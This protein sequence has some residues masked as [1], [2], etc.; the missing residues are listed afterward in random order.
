LHNAR[1]LYRLRFADACP[2]PRIALS[3]SSDMGSE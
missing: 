2:H 3:A 1:Q